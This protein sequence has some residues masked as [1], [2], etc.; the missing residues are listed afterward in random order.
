[1][2]TNM[3]TC[4]QSRSEVERI[5]RRPKGGNLPCAHEKQFDFNKE[6]QES[7]AIAHQ[8]FSKSHWQGVKYTMQIVNEISEEI[9]RKET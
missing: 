6:A 7:W 4:N 8:Q 3:E 5:C 9:A 1:V 2:T